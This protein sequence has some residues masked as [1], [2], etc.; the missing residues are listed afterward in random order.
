MSSKSTK[1]LNVLGLLIS[2]AVACACT[3][4]AA[5]P[6]VAAFMTTAG[7]IAGN[8][9]AEH[10]SKLFSFSGLN[11]FGKKE[12]TGLHAEL[13]KAL[14]AAV[15]QSLEQ[16][17]RNYSNPSEMAEIE[18]LITSWKSGAVEILDSGQTSITAWNQLV[19]G[20]TSLQS[21]LNDLG[22]ELYAPNEEYGQSEFRL[23]FLENF[24]LIFATHFQTEL[25]KNQNAWLTWEVLQ[26]KAHQKAILEIAQS[27]DHL[28][29]QQKLILEKLADFQFSVKN[30]SVQRSEFWNAFEVA[31]MEAQKANLYD[32]TFLFCNTLDH[33]WVTQEVLPV[34]Q[35]AAIPVHLEN[36]NYQVTDL[37][38]W[39]NVV[40]QCRKTLVLKTANFSEV[41]DFLMK[42]YKLSN[43]P[44]TVEEKLLVLEAADLANLSHIA[45]KL[46]SQ[47][48]TS[49]EQIMAAP[50]FPPLAEAHIRISNMPYGSKHI[51]FGRQDERKGRCLGKPGL[52]HPLFCSKRRSG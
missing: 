33:P 31:W 36:R 9:G 37:A 26:S 46:Q 17:K 29:A 16:I 45:Q 5:T 47:L 34:F 51:L 30:I 27:L 10:F 32:K 13:R 2:C 44:E 48:T 15:S 49:H 42:G 6:A 24:P 41:E 50:A 39:S 1:I 19:V 12:P 7:G 35:K 20:K 43:Q 23:F 21:T 22:M 3:G 4:G 14:I 11:F 18:E 8:V 52:P 28:K 25:E 38:G 40:G